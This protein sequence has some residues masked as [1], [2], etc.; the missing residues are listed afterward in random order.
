MK[1][2]LNVNQLN[3]IPTMNKLFIYL[4]IKSNYYIIIMLVP[5]E[6]SLL[7]SS[8]V[9]MGAINKSKDGSSLRKL[10]D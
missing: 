7:L 2:L 6:I 1:A 10:R 8:D 9:D 4:F 5:E 3:L